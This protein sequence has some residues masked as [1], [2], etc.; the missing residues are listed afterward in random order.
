LRFKGELTT[1]GAELISGRIYLLTVLGSKT[2]SCD[3]STI[4]SF[5]RDKS[6]FL[7]LPDF[8]A[9]FFDYFF[10][11]TNF[12]GSSNGSAGDFCRFLLVCLTN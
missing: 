7:G 9:P 4:N 11:L 5:F 2:S 8:D 10:A 3:S 12:S 1:K 6:E